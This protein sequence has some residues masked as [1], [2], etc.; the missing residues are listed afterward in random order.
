AQEDRLD[1]LYTL[2]A[3]LEDKAL[4]F[5]LEREAAPAETAPEA[6]AK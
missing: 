1:L 5:L 4:R 3:G 2:P 6:P